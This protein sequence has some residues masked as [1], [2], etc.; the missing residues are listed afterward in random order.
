M[1]RRTGAKAGQPPELVQLAAAMKQHQAGRIDAAER[2]YRQILARVPN[3]KGAL[4]FLGMLL[5]D[6]G[7]AAAAVPLLRRALNQ[8]P[9]LDIPACN[10]LGVALQT[11]GRYD[12]AMAQYERLLAVDPRHALAH[13]NLSSVFRLLG[14]NEEAVAAATRAVAIDPTYADAYNNVGTA[15]H[16]LDRDEEALNWFAKAVHLKPDDSK[17][18]S[19][20]GV[21]LRELGRLDE[22]LLAF[23]HALDLA[24]RTASYYRLRVEAAAFPADHRHLAGLWALD[25]GRDALLVPERI[26]LAFACAKAAADA[27]DYPRSLDRLIEGNALRRGQIVYDEAAYLGQMS[28]LAATFTP[29]LFQLKRQPEP[30]A[31]PIP[32]FVIGMPRSGSTLV[33]Q[34]LAS[35]PDL[36]G[37]GE[38][39]LLARIFPTATG[40]S[41]IPDPEGAA[42][43]VPA[44]LQALGDRY[45]A[46]IAQVAPGASGVVNKMLGN[47][48]EVGL[49]HLAL[50]QARFIHTVRD[51]VDTCLSCFSQLFIREQHYTFDLGELGRYY[52]A[53]AALMVHWH[54]VLPAGTLIDVQYEAMVA[55]PE[56][57]ARRLMAHCGVPWDPACLEFWKTN[58]PV[59]TASASQVRRPIYQ[60]SVGRWRAYGAGLA[61][62]F[63]ALGQELPS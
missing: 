22:A 29:S 17:A 9:V 57:Q 52:R 2:A 8:D 48:L 12:E 61:P 28:R 53:Y 4:K 7:Q 37:L 24:P 3:Q 49:I 34:V 16:A 42:A 58:R 56:Q 51:P 6:R 60:N 5:L 38:T 46:E 32:I 18:P 21:V 31:G 59:R 26:E 40:L 27:G 62:L 44:Q 20:I 14:R 13:S 1:K 25:A 41:A 33:E 47:F 35:H 54:E 36:R 10:N 45:L 39:D 63:A 23:D 55:D 15:L 30:A 11:L 43:L 50:P 19:N